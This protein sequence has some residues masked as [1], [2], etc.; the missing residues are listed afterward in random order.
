MN[1]QHAI[2]TGGGAAPRD[3]Q[4]NPWNAAYTIASGNLLAD[5]R[6]NVTA[7]SQ[8]RLQVARPLPADPRLG[9]A[10]H[11]LVLARPRH[12]APEPVAGGHRGPEGRRAGGHL[13]ALQLSP[14]AGDE[15]GRLQ[16]S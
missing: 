10:R 16:G 8:G 15:R 14:G 3:S 1:P 13:G 5:M 9:R 2:V 4:G 7:E 11:V 6:F 12:H